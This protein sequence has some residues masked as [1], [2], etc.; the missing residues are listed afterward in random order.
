MPVDISK[1]IAQTQSSE[2]PAIEQ[3]ESLWGYYTFSQTV[4]L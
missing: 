2:I 1:I 3:Y 4:Q